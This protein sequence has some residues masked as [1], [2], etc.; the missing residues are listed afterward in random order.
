MAR[1]LVDSFGEKVN[2][3][4]RGGDL[5]ARKRLRSGVSVALVLFGE[6]A[7]LGCAGGV[8]GTAGGGEGWC[9]TLSDDIMEGEGQHFESLLCRR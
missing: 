5:G 6:S 3:V 1:L 2:R 8:F 9:T 7:M 4:W